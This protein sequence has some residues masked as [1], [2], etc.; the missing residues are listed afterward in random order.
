V[1]AKL[2]LLPQWEDEIRSKTN[3]TFATYY[4]AQGARDMSVS[5]LEK[6][7]VILTTYGTIQGELTRKNPSLLKAK[8]LRVILDEA[9]CCRNE[10]T[11]A[12][13]AA[14]SLDASHRWAV[15]GTIMVN[16]V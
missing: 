13:R 8:W 15:S 4:G 14:C 7:D 6:M 1:V 16:G 11:L 12:S 10:R 3:L 9:H 5:E 2:S